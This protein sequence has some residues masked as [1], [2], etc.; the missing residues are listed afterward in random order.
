MAKPTRSPMWRHSMARARGLLLI[1]VTS[2]GIVTA[3]CG[4]L[5]TDGQV[6]A[7]SQFSEATKGFGTSPGT[8]IAAYADLRS[9]RALLEANSRSDGGVAAKDLANGLKQRLELESR[10]A[11]ADAAIGV[12]D[13]YAQ[14]LGLLSSSKF[15][16][17]LQNQ[18]IA[19]GSS[20]DNG[21]ATFNKLSGSQLNSFGDIVAGIVRGAGGLGIRYAQHKALVAAV[22]NAKGPIDRLTASIESLMDFFIGPAPS[23]DPEKNLFARESREVQ[24]FL[25]RTPPAGRAL[26]VLERTQMVMQQAVDGENLAQLSRNAAAKYRAAHNELV[27]AVTGDKADLK[28]LVGTIQGLSQ[29][30]KAAKRVQGDVKKARD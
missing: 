28:N 26:P 6:A 9:D 2:A 25:G 23:T 21:V 3:G 12:L 19:L 16:E 18:T 27:Q 22:T 1:A 24:D 13:D 11:T 7:V 20:I 10:A 17:D 30:I 29:E 8:V 4:G 15:T 5:L 14:M